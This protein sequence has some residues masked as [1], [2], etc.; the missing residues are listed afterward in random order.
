MN[1][2]SK[3][4]T[5]WVYLLRCKDNSLYAGVTTDIHRR[6]NEH[7]NSKLGAKYTLARRPVSLAYLEQA[8][9][10]SS[11][12]KR[13]YQI[14]QLSKVKKEQLVGNYSEDDSKANK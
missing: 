2:H 1:K 12:C 11:A 14:R 4:S 3:K 9:D 5:W 10:K 8:D 6:T 13:E 7:N